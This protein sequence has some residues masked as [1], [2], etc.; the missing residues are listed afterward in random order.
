MADRVFCIDF[1]SSYTK[2]ALRRDPSADAE[3]IRHGGE[4]VS[5]EDYWF[6]ST[7]VVDRTG[8]RPVPEFGERALGRVADARVE[9]HRDWKKWLFLTPAPAAAAVPPLDA[10]LRSDEFRTLAAKYQVPAVAVAS[11]QQLATAATGLYSAAGGRMPSVETQQQAFA[12]SLAVYFFKWVRD[13]V[14]AACA[15]LPTTGLKFDEIPVRVT[16][17]AL[18]DGPP[19]TRPGAKALA[20]ALAKAGWPL[21]PD[22]PV[23]TEPYSNAIGV[24]TGGANAVAPRRKVI[25]LGKMFSNGPL[26]TVM[27]DPAH[28]PSYRAL[29]VDIGSFTTDLAAVTFAPN[30]ETVEDLDAAVG[31]TQMSLPLGVTDLD[32]AVRS[33][34]PAEKAAA[35]GQLTG[36]DRE[37]F[38]RMVYADGKGYRR[39]GLSLGG[40]GDEAV[41]AAIAGVAAKVAEAVSAFCERTPPAFRQE[42][43]LT[44]GGS[45]VP[46]L[47]DAVQSAAATHGHS[48]VKT[49]APFAKKP[50]AGTLVNR[51]DD[52]TARGGSAI[53][54]AS[55]FFDR[56]F[57]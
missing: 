1:G 13:Q 37:D 26:I 47:R 46:A 17:P 30:G 41:K 44:G 31:V 25:L 4:T 57:Y 27:K 14:L 32:D 51:L 36:R 19:E 42:L 43:I 2:V 33:G 24:L 52:R 15:K 22:R 40:P 8:P 12:A 35:L 49:H 55:I 3:L 50:P 21:H 7:V 20:A 6:P 53:G 16:V 54:G 23:V 9:V 5:A 48:Y 18:G 29:V 45:L 11:L 38:R 10:L 34:L 39:P 28:Y 56:D